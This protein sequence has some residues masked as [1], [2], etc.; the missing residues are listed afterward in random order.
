VYIYQ[1]TTF[2]S[3]LKDLWIN[4]WSV[5]SR[6]FEINVIVIVIEYGLWLL[7]AALSR[8]QLPV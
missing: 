7:K 3:S 6:K 5:T 1:S 8:A 4:Q 2:S